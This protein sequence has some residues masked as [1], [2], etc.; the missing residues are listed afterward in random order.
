METNKRFR[1]SPIED[2]SNL[3]LVERRRDDGNG[4]TINKKEFVNFPRKFYV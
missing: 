3:G 1:L 2:F 4:K